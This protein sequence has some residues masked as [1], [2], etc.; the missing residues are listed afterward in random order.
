[1]SMR[2][3]AEWM[4]QLDERILEYI[5]EEEWASPRLMSKVE[6]LR[7]SEGRIKERC[8]W[9][10]RAGLLAPLFEGA[11][12]YELTTEGL[13]YLRGS[14]DAEH[15]TDPRGSEQFIR[16]RWCLRRR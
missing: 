9:M 6:E 11:N 12:S 1:M 13:L 8:V 2:K 5:H 16:R 4:Q 15:L 14:L 7:G 10:H 3:R